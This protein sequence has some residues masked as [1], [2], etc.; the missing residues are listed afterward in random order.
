MFSVFLYSYCPA[1]D[2]SIPKYAA[3]ASSLMPRNSSSNPNHPSCLS[4]NLPVHGNHP[5]AIKTQSFGC[6]SCVFK[7][8]ESWRS[9]M[10]PSLLSLA[11]PYLAVDWS[12]CPDDWLG[13]VSKDG[14]VISRIIRTIS[15]EERQKVN[16]ST[17]L[18]L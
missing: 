3:D 11:L 15:G 1:S 14:L 2:W 9:N 12:H 17:C 10:C 5:H 4:L 13:A 8:K 18:S 16:K 6:L 7:T